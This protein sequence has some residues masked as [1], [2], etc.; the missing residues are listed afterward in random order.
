MKWEERVGDIIASTL[1]K[2]GQF[3]RGELMHKAGIPETPEGV[4]AFHHALHWA[5]MNRCRELKR[6]IVTDRGE[7][8]Y[9]MPLPGEWRPLIYDWLPTVLKDGATRSETILEMV[10]VARLNHAARIPPRVLLRM[11]RL[12]RMQKEH[13]ASAGDL[14]DALLEI[15]EGDPGNAA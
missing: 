3:S 4:I 5:R 8:L 9:E 1:K 11:N 10:E 15:I 13:H 14:M 6:E 7:N 2:G 12:V